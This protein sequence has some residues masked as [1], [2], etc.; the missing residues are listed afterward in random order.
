MRKTKTEN[1]NFV[2][3]RNADAAQI[4][5]ISPNRD[6]N[7]PPSLSKLSLSQSGILERFSKVLPNSHFRNGGISR[8]WSNIFIIF[9]DNNMK[10]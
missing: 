10:H 4:I 9:F 1:E 7:Q 2:Q 5:K 3:A 6:D 8:N